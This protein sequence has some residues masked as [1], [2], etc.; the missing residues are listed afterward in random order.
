[1]FSGSASCRH[2]KAGAAA[3]V[4]DAVAEVAVARAIDLPDQ[5]ER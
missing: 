3:V 5:V 4:A 1:M 2:V